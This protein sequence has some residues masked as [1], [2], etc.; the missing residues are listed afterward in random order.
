MSDKK[1][2]KTGTSDSSTEIRHVHPTYAGYV[3]PVH[4][5]EGQEVGLIKQLAI[6][7]IISKESDSWGLMEYILTCE[8]IEKIETINVSEKFTKSVCLVYVNGVLIGFTRLTI[9]EL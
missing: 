1:Q 9:V 5:P 4:S 2:G 6:T 7:A 3:C 8:N